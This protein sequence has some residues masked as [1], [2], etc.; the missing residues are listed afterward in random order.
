MEPED[1]AHLF[2][3]FRSKPDLIPVET[4][5]S[6]LDSTSDDLLQVGVDLLVPLD[7]GYLMRRRD[8]QRIAKVIQ[9]SALHAGVLYF[10][11][12][13]YSPLIPGFVEYSR[14]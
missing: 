10:K 13:L 7:P 3:A 9:E 8:D 14:T 5:R 6:L 12:R 2:G 1:A 4:A 11:D